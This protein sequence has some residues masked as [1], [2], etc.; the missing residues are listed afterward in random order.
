MPVFRYGDQEWDGVPH[1]GV[2]MGDGTVMRIPRGAIIAIIEDPTRLDKVLPM[3]ITKVTMKAL[4]F[5]CA[6]GN[7]D[8]TR[9]LRY[10]AER[11]G[12]HPPMHRRRSQ[13]QESGDPE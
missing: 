8:C 9:K 6:C 7:P 2:Y 3:V 4:D 12:Y 1:L 10:R 5:K 13:I 11:A